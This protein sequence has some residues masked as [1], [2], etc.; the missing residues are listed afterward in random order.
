MFAGGDDDLFH[1]HAHFIGNSNGEVF[2]FRE[3]NGTRHLDNFFKFA[4]FNFRKFHLGGGQGP[5]RTGKQNAQRN[6]RR[7]D[8]HTP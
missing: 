1:R 4:V 2:L 7:Q 5:E 3:N 6:D 8:D